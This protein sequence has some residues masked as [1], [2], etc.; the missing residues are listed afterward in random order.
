MN[1]FTDVF[2]APAGLNRKREGQVKVSICVPRA[3][4]AEPQGGECVLPLR[5]CS[6]RPRG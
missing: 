2:P 5:R 3:R 4:G 6:P 1:L